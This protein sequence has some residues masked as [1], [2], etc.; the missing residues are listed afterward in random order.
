MYRTAKAIVAEVRMM[1]VGFD[2]FCHI[3]GAPGENDTCITTALP[4]RGRVSALPIFLLNPRCGIEPRCQARPNLLTGDRRD[5]FMTCPDIPTAPQH[6]RS[7]HGNH[8]GAS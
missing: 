3:S 1:T 8:F 2:N 5:T 4:A 7:E 6:L